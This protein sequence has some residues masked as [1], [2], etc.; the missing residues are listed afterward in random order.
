MSDSTDWDEGRRE[1]INLARAESLQK[2]LEETGY[3]RRPWPT[4]PHPTHK[5]TIPVQGALMNLLIDYLHI[6]DKEK[7][8]VELSKLQE[9]VETAYALFEKEPRFR[10]ET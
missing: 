5:E 6:M 10:Q 2:A 3:F 8:L 7:Q 4:V 1:H 9:I